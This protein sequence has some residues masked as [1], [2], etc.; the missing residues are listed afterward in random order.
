MTSELRYESR[1]SDSDSLMW[2]IEKDPL[3]RSTITAVSLLDGPIDP[4]RFRDK[5]ERASRVIPRLRQRVVGNPYSLAPPRWEVDP[6][7]DLGYHLRQVHAGGEGDERGV[8]DLAQWVGMQGFDRAR[9]LWELYLVGG[10][11]GGR[12]A[13]IQK[14]HHAIT[15]GASS[16]QMALTLFDLEREPADPGPM[17]DAPGAHVLGPMER[18]VDGAGYVGRRRLTTLQRSVGAVSGGLRGALADPVDA[19]R[20]LTDTVGSVGRLLAPA[21]APL[22]PLM[23]DRSL[24]MRFATLVR[25]LAPLRAAAKAADGKL[26]DAFVAAV[27]GGLQ[28]YHERL[29]APVEALRMTMPISVRTEATEGVVGNQFVPARFPVPTSISDPIERMRAIRAL[30]ATQ[31]GEPAL[32][33]TEPIAGILN[34]LP[35]SVTT[36]VFGGMLRCVD[37][38]TSN[39][40]GAPIPLYASGAE[41]VQQFAFGPLSG[42]A[43]NVT[44]LSWLD[45]VCIGINVDPAAVSD[46]DA[47]QACLVAGFDEVLAVG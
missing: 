4:E 33:L 1:M 45:Q 37:F 25:P 34:R 24:S 22:S 40:P 39:V 15:D 12:S 43:T 30:V 44:L 18:L 41:I 36:G 23:A 35:T 19:A 28:R 27:A 5:V 14:V 9:P 29:G 32:G 6:N 38:V 21:M 47:F 26:N 17:P 42:A 16:I 46:P 3:L 2:T 31:R 8:L 10:M 11:A 7:F 20:R 13:L